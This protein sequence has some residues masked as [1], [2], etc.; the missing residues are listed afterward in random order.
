VVT[1]GSA[2]ELETQLVD[3]RRRLEAAGI[4]RD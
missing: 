1:P 3:A 2:D 4:T